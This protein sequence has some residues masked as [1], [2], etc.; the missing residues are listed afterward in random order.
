MVVATPEENRS[1]I[2]NIRALIFSHYLS[3]SQGQEEIGN[4]KLQTQVL[5]SK[6]LRV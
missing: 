2:E 5:G 3:Y 4:W 1:T 6:N